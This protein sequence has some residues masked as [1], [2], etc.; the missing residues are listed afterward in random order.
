MGLSPRSP[1][2]KRPK[3]QLTNHPGMEINTPVASACTR[4]C[5]SAWS[6]GDADVCEMQRIPRWS[7]QV[8]IQIS[9]FS[10]T[11]VVHVIPNFLWVAATRQI[12][13]AGLAGA[14]TSRYKCSRQLPPLHIPV[15]PTRFCRLTL[16]Y[17]PTTPLVRCGPQNHRFTSS[18]LLHTRLSRLLRL[19][20]RALQGP[21]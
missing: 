14:R 3:V 7:A 2:S 11:S 17:L 19:S 13:P 8:G 6:G 18:S 15:F 16:L 1:V 21:R 9:H 12:A 5:R 4:I 10:A 20:P